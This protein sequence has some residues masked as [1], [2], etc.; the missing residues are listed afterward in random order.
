VARAKAAVEDAAMGYMP[1]ENGSTDHEPESLRI[2]AGPLLGIVLAII[3]MVILAI[4]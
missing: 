4:A 3:A 1:A 2:V